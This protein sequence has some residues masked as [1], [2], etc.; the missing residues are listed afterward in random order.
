M[1]PALSSES[2]K[3]SVGL[4]DIAD[5]LELSVTTVSRSLRGAPG[6]NPETRARVKETAMKLGYSRSRRGRPAAT[7]QAHRLAM[8]LSPNDYSSTNQ[9]YLVGLS[10][11]SLEL[12]F[13]LLVH[14]VGSEDC[15]EILTP[16]S[17]PAPMRNEEVAGLILLHGWPQH[18]VSQLAEKWPVVSIIHRY[19]DPKVDLVGID[20]HQGVRQILDHLI[21]QGHER[22]GFFGF[23][24]DISWSTGRFAAFVEQMAVHG[25]PWRST[26]LVSISS[27]EA[28]A[29]SPFPVGSW[30]KDVTKRVES[31]VRC[32]VCPS[33][34]IAQSLNNAL[35]A[36]GRKVPQ[37]VAVTGF[38]RS[39]LAL[40]AVPPITSTDLEQNEELGTAAL[41]LLASRIESPQQYRQIVQFPLELVKGKTT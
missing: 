11:A 17:Q 35:K 19:D 31:G 4:V 21:S 27:S 5:Q 12:N 1:S 36:T 23:N 20:D 28:Y 16:S 38:H 14:H 29:P 34:A 2:T 39:A 3:S 9:R 30:L 15:E 8:I 41:R 6:I 13:G 33:D 26:D 7:S 37:D 24:R 40:P 25:L 10:A 18:V 32:W 22:I